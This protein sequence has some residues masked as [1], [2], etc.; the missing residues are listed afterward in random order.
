M[1]WNNCD[2]ISEGGVYRITMKRLQPLSLNKQQVQYIRS[3]FLLLLMVETLP[4]LCLL[5][6]LAVLT[7]LMPIVQPYLLLMYQAVFSFMLL[8]SQVRSLRDG[9]LINVIVN[10]GLM[11]FVQ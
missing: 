7:T 9:E 1:S 10:Q 2:S 3:V 5:V 4:A 8:Q 11:V 6:S